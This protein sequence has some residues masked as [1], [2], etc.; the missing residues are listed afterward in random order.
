M[1][2]FTNI[3]IYL[4]I[5]DIL[6]F[7][8][9]GEESSIGGRRG[10]RRRGSI[11]P[12]GVEG[13]AFWFRWRVFVALHFIYYYLLY[14]LVW[15]LVSCVLLV[16][17]F[18]FVVF[19]VFGAKMQNRIVWWFEKLIIY[20]IVMPWSSKILSILLLSVLTHVWNNNFILW[21]SV[22]VSSCPLEN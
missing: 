13:F 14:F 17:S 8:P 3:Y 21:L 4:Y 20:Y 9:G 5:K 15:L 19:C 2:I 10:R 1:Q 12:Q 11:W 22:L 18:L 7:N 6:F 16:V